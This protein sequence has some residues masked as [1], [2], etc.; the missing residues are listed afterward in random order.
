MIAL[1][2]QNSTSP[3][4]S[5]LLGCFA[6]MLRSN[7]SI[8]QAIAGRFA[9]LI[10]AIGLKGGH[11][12]ASYGVD[13]SLVLALIIGIILSFGMPFL[14]FSLLGRQALCQR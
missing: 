11:S 14:A 3:M 10:M 7:L 13:Q 9:Y 5:F 6:A 12:L 2:V 4:I 8:P 1:T